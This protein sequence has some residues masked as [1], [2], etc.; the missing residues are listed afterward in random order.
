M[1]EVCLKKPSAQN[2][3]DMFAG[4]WS[5][6]MPSGSGLVSTG[7]IPLFEDQRMTWLE[8]VLG[9]VRGMNVLEL[10]PLEGGHTYVL[11]QLGARSIVSIEANSRAFLRC[12]AVKEIFDLNR[13]KFE[14]GSFIPYLEELPSRPDL[15]V[16]SGVLYHM[17]EPLRVLELLCKATDKLF[18]WSH[19]YDAGIIRQRADAHLFAP[20]T[21]VRSGS[22]QCGGSVRTYPREALDWKGF[23]GGS[24]PYSVWLTRDGILGFLR[25]RGFGTIA[26]EFEQR[27]HPNGPALALCAR[28]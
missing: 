19:Y 10:G 23:S 28:R 25:E 13:A 22:Y 16:A 18:I 4:E 3:V 26:V 11:H 14:L 17:T 21:V 7:A 5:S 27:D 9:P 15:V 12:L 1:T 6:Q 24:T 2:V 8:Q 20:E